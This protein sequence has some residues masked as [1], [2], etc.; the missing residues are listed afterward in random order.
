MSHRVIIIGQIAETPEQVAPTKIRFYLA[1]TIGGDEKHRTIW[2]TIFANG[3]LAL[4]HRNLQKGQRLLIE[5]VLT[6]DQGGHPYVRANSEGK[7]FARY[8]VRALAISVMGTSSSDKE[9]P[10]SVEGTD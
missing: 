1:S 9:I 2:F 8:E 6:A 10:D 3:R 7:S 4:T 5:G